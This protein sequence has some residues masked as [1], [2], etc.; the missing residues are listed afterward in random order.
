MFNFFKKER[1]L[2][3]IA[4]GSLMDITLVPDE[5]FS[6]KILGTGFAVMPSDGKFYSPATGTVTEV[7][8][9]LHAYCITSNDGLEILVHIGLDTVKL[10][11]KFFTPK[12]KTGDRIQKGAPLVSADINSI[13]E[14]GYNPIS[15]VVVTNS[16]KLSSFDTIETT[17]ASPGAKAF[18]YKI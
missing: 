9:T 12:V 4:S 1:Y 13:K 11:G 6:K 8:K 7:S 2:A 15:M 5:V 10:G 18:I 14:S 3:S 16:N 17:S